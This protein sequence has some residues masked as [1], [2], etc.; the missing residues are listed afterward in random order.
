MKKYGIIRTIAILICIA[1]LFSLT[2]CTWFMSPEERQ[3]L[4]EQTAFEN[5]DV[6]PLLNTLDEF[7]QVK[8][9][10]SKD[11]VL[12]VLNKNDDYLN[13]GKE[14][15]SDL[16][17]TYTYTIDFDS[18]KADVPY[19]VEISYSIDSKSNRVTSM[20]YSIS[21]SKSPNNALLNM[22]GLLTKD[23]VVKNI[24]SH[25]SGASDE[26][27][28]KTFCDLYL[29]KSDDKWR[30]MLKS[31]SDENHIGI[32]DDTFYKPEPTKPKKENTSDGKVGDNNGDGKVDE[33]DWEQEWKD[34]INK[35]MNEN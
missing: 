26:T 30:L 23:E 10:M 3:E 31:K 35:K 13:T 27:A 34:Y 8:T 20:G 24:K 29:S 1:S 25:N 5:Y 14:K 16:W 9:G 4:A 21:K 17:R 19:Q 6:T 12:E 32:I 33:E 15:T 18:Y 22:E 2:G 11:D 28:K 7:F